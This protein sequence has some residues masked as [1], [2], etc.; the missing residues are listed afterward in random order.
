M[1]NIKEYYYDFTQINSDDS[2]FQQTISVKEGN[3]ATFTKEIIGITL[4]DPKWTDK[5]IA[6]KILQLISK[7]YKTVQQ[8]QKAV[9]ELWQRKVLEEESKNKEIASDS[10]IDDLEEETDEDKIDYAKSF[11][12][13]CDGVDGYDSVELYSLILESY[14]QK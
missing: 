4:K 9:A 13:Y 5:K 3:N 2:K 11:L 6:R 7:Y 14:Y 1:S 12:D 10:I 8:R